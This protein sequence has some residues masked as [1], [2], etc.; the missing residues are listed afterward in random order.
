[1]DG[2]ELRAVVLQIIDELSTQN[3]TLQPGAVLQRARQRLGIQ[4]LEDQQALLSFF[5]DLF[6]IGYLSWGGDIGNP[7]PPFF[8]VA[9]LGRK[10]LAQRS[11]DPANPDGYLSHLRATSGIAA[12]TE[13]Y[14]R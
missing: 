2:T 3:A 11:R 12:I 5:Y 9:S 13:S 6:R 7:S 10:A 8:H 1:M 4:T 14:I